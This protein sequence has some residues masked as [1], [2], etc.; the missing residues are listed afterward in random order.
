MLVGQQ[1]MVQMKRN[2]MFSIRIINIKNGSEV[3]VD[4]PK[5][6][7]VANGII[8]CEINVEILR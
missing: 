5:D 8:N 7:G 1:Y 4:N 3:V 2:P 6:N